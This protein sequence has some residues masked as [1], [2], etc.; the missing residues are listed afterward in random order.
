MLHLLYWASLVVLIVAVAVIAFH[1]EI[2]GGWFGTLSLGGVAVF[3]I[4]MF[5][6]PPPDDV[7]QTMFVV[8]L[9]W[10]AVWAVGRWKIETARRPSCPCK[11]G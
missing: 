5:D 2:P 1:P 7:A 11:H 4:A 10:V 6:R 8:C 9:A 3:G